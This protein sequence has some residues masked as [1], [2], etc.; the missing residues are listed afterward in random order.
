MKT[1]EKLQES[2]GKRRKHIQR[3][4][5]RPENRTEDNSIGGVFRNHPSIH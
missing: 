4:E 1:G 2:R 3:R 5:K